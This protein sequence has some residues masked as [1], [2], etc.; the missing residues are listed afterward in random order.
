MLKMK[1]MKTLKSG[2]MKRIAAIF[3][4]IAILTLNSCGSYEDCRSAEIQKNQPQTEQ[5]IPA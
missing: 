4:I 3:G 2:F 5:S 1:N